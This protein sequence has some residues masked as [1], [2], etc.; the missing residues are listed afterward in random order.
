MHPLRRL[1]YSVSTSSARICAFDNFKLD[2]FALAVPYGYIITK[3]GTNTTQ[4]N[5]QILGANI[6]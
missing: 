2:L 3:L 6:N 5:K 4:N 1:N